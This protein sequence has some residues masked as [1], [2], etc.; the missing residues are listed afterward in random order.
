MAEKEAVKAAT[1]ALKETAKAAKR[2]E[3]EAEKAVE[4]AQVSGGLLCLIFHGD[5][6]LSLQICPCACT[7]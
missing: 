6:I 7:H 3:K 4:K 1:K 5:L 2:A